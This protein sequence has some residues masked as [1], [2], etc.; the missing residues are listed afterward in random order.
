MVTSLSAVKLK[1]F[2]QDDFFQSSK[3]TRSKKNIITAFFII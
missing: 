1:G 2:D 3:N